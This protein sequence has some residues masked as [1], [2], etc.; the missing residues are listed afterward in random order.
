MRIN[1]PLRVDQLKQ[2]LKKN[3]L[4]KA[5]QIVFNKKVS[6]F[7]YLPRWIIFSIDIGILIFAN[8]ITYV[9]LTDL[10]SRFYTMLNV[11]ES[12][13]LIVFVNIFFFVFYRTYAGIIRHSSFTDAVKLLFST[14]TSLVALEI[15]N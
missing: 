15:I 2:E 12:Y 13:A 4:N 14:F 9:M 1:E 7:G 3:L 11:Y 6:S 5:I 8:I 10:N